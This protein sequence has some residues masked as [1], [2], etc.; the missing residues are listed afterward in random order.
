MGLVQELNPENAA[1]RVNIRIR[2]ELMWTPILAAELR[3]HRISGPF[4]AFI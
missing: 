4:S 2:R 1:I 3:T